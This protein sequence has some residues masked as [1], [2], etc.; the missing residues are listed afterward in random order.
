MMIFSYAKKGV[1]WLAFFTCLLLLTTFHYP[2]VRSLHDIS[3]LPK[4]HIGDWVLRQGT[5]LDSKIIMQVSNSRFS[6]IGMIVATEPVPLVIHATT[7]DGYHEK[8]QV[9]LSPLR[10]FLSPNLAH[11]YMIIRPHFLTLS[12]KHEIAQRLRQT[13]GQPFRLA[14]KNQPHLYCTTLLADHIQSVLPTFQPHWQAISVPL[15]QGEYLMPRAF[16]HYPDTEI[17]YQ[18]Y[19]E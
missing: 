3:H 15:M 19:P 10:E 18:S 8:N 13:E 9:F 7:D 5:T 16:E 1:Q 2:K 4:L 12:Q 17:L 11:A 6:H 14:T